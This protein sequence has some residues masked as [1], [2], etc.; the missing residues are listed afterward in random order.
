MSVGNWSLAR[1]LIA[2]SIILVLVI[3]PI[4]GMGLS[5]SFRESAAASFDERLISMH[6]VLLASFETDP[7][8]GKLTLKDRLSDPRFERVYSGWYWEISDGDAFTRTSRSLWDQR[9]PLSNL[10][11]ISWRT[12]KGPR[13]QSLRI[14]EQVLLFPGQQQPMRVS[15]A[16]SRQELVAETARFERLLWLSLV[17]LSVLL[18]T[19]LTLQIHWGLAPLRALREDLGAIKSGNRERLE[20]QL[21][22]ELAELAKTMNEVLD[23]DRCLIERGRVTAGNLAHALKTPVSVLQAQADHLSDTDV[24]RQQIRAEVARINAAVRHHLARASAV[25]NSALTASVEIEKVLSPIVDGLTRLAE[26]RGKRLARHFTSG[27]MLRIDPQDLQELAGNLLEN[28]LDWS[29]SRVKIS[30]WP[31]GEGAC[32]LFEDDGPGMPPEQRQSVLARGSRLDEKRPGNGLG[33]SI[34]EDLVELYGGRLDLGEASLGGL[35]ARVW[36]PGARCS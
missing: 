13:G 4:V 12:I 20:T 3:V 2:A 17:V 14:V 28:A 36:L 22:G 31:D 21:S 27:L 1:R 19:G 32:L 9:L 15:L 26:R 5:F 23:H 11:G 29:A 18:L 34:V 25:G 8:T 35:S 24:A 30:C 6:K 10:P 33:L 16:V 7:V